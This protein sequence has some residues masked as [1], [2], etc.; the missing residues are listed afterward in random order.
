MENVHA[1]TQN[2][3]STCSSELPPN[4]LSAIKAADT[5]LSAIIADPSSASANLKT[6]VSQL[7][8]VRL[9][10]PRPQKLMNIPS[11]NMENPTLH[12][13]EQGPPP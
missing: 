11:L 6:L 3:L 2:V 5:T 1:A 12:N 8:A 10:C 4:C 7:A 13:F 9:S